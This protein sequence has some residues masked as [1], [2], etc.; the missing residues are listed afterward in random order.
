MTAEDDLRTLAEGDPHA[1]GLVGAGDDYFQRK[2]VTVISIKSDGGALAAMALRLNPCP[3]D[4]TATW[5]IV[6]WAVDRTLTAERLRAALVESL[7][8]AVLAGG[9]A[10]K[11]WGVVFEGD[12]H[13]HLSGFLDETVKAGACKRTITTEGA[14][15][16]IYYI[17]DLSAAQ[18]YLERQ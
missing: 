5:Q 16:F 14:D 18:R 13:S 15:P 10:R 6:Y 8:K 4:D 9:D 17:A 3:I 12:A 1:K 2:G 11:I 7:L